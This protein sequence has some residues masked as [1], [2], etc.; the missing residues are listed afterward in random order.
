MEELRSAAEAVR[1]NL[2]LPSFDESAVGRLGEF[3]D[4]ERSTINHEARPG[5]VNAL[6]CFLGEC[7][8]RSFGG[9]WHRDASGLVGV[10]VAG[11]TFINPFSYVERQLVQGAA[12]SVMVLFRSV[13]S[14]LAAAATPRRRT[15]IPVP[16]PSRRT[17]SP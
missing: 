15:W 1:Q 17:T 14:R 9:Y 8:I 6:G 13:P 3:I 4:R 5:V 11:S 10:Q 7:I 12:E 16:L 2:N